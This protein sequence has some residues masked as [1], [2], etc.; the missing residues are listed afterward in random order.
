MDIV[1]C[2]YKA[3]NTLERCLTSLECQTIAEL[4]SIY[5][6]IDGC[7]ENYQETVL[8]YQNK[9]HIELIYLRK[10]HGPGYARSIGL[11]ACKSKYV[12]FLDADDEIIA[13]DSLEMVYNL[14]EKENADIII[15]NYTEKKEKKN[16]QLFLQGKLYKREL[17]SKYKIDFPKL[18]IEEPIGFCLAAQVLASKVIEIENV[19]AVYRR[20]NKNSIT[21]TWK[22]PILSL[23]S[24]ISAYEHAIKKTQKSGK[25]QLVYEFSS[26]IMSMAYNNFDRYYNDLNPDEITLYVKKVRKFYLKYKN[27]IDRDRYKLFGINKLIKLIERGA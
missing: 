9:L 23:N 3:T 22:D 10:N 5:L 20:D 4:L 17:L 12:Y 19:I 15:G 21:K 2:A 14:A 11:K 25:V 1:I 7:K 18:R 16:N 8:K 6:V 26:N 27:Y 24:L 13:N